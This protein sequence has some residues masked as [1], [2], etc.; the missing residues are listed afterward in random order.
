MKAYGREGEKEKST[1][2]DDIMEMRR[3]ERKAEVA[4]AAAACLINDG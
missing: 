2:L 4:L 3:T 1:A